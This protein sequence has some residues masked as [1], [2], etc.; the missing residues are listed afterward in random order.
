MLV[1]VHDPRKAEA[2]LPWIVLDESSILSFDLP[3]WILSFPDFQVLNLNANSQSYIFVW[4][5]HW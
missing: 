5:H 3:V 2:A 1:V 4:P